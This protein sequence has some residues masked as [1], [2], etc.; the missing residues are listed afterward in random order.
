MG[1]G[2]EVAHMWHAT[3]ACNGGG[4]WEPR[5]L[6]NGGRLRGA[7]KKEEVMG[8]VVLTLVEARCT[9][10]TGGT[11]IKGGVVQAHCSA[12]VWR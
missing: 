11:K 9:G 5:V 12:T 8:M 1:K 4:A 10:I 6:A 2:D 7:R 3:S